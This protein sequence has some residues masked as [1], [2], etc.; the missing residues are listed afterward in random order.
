MQILCRGYMSVVKISRLILYILTY[1]NRF[2][3]TNSMLSKCL[4]TLELILKYFNN[5]YYNVAVYTIY[6]YSFL[7]SPIKSDFLSSN[8]NYSFQSSIKSNCQN[9]M[10]Y[11]IFFEISTELE[12][13]SL[14]IIFFTAGALLSSLFLGLLFY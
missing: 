3:S 5:Q 2:F 13:D 9:L 14:I 7:N 10:E 4:Q 6:R 8:C 11:D 12:I 1:W